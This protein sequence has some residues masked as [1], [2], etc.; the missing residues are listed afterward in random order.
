MRALHI[1]T[2]YIGGI[3]TVPAVTAKF[4]DPHIIQASLKIGLECTGFNGKP[5]AENNATCKKSPS[6]PG[7]A[8]TPVGSLAA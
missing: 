3:Q 1:C 6:G 2:P 8:K 7:V 5:V 4:Y